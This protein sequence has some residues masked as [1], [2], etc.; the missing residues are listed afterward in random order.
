MLKSVC[1]AQSC[2]CDADLAMAVTG[3][4][5]MAA[6]AELGGIGVQRMGNYKLMRNDFAIYVQTVD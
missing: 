5:G 6:G 2:A 3:Q 4:R 1:Q